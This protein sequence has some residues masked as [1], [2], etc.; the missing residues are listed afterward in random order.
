[1]QCHVKVE[2]KRLLVKTWF[3]RGYI[4]SRKSLGC[5]KA[6]NY[7]LRWDRGEENSEVL[8]R[9]SGI[10]NW[11]PSRYLQQGNWIETAG[12]VVGEQSPI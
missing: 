10:R 11:S 7:T 1:M 2:V 12:V 9:V 5:W 8:L 6:R 3:I 4:E